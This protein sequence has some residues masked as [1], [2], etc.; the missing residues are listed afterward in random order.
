MEQPA[1]FLQTVIQQQRSYL[2]NA[3]A[4][5]SKAVNND[6]IGLMKDEQTQN[7]D[8]GKKEDVVALGKKS[9]PVWKQRARKMVWPLHARYPNV[10]PNPYGEDKSHYRERDAENNAKTA[11]DESVSLRLG[12]IMVS[13][14]FGPSEIETLY[15]GLEK[16]G[17]DGE[18]VPVRD[19]SNIDWL[20]KQRLYGSEGTMPLGWIHR[21]EEVKKY[22][23][24]RYTADFP[25]EFSSLLV[26]IAQL[27]PSITCLSV[28]F[29]LTDDASLEYANAINEPAKTTR[30]PKRRSR[31]YSIMGVEHV[32]EERVRRIRGKYRNVGI[33]W[34]SKNFPGFFSEH[35]E[36]SHFPTVEFLSLDGFT[37]FDKD[38]PRDRSWNHWSRFVNID[39]DFGSWTSSSIPSLKFSFDA[40]HRKNTPN[41]MTVALRWDVL[42]EEDLKTYGGDSLGTRTYFANDRLDGIIAR[43]ALASYLRELLRS[44]KETRQ[45]LSARS[46]ARCST[47]AIEHISAFFRQSIGVPSIAREVRAL[48]EN[49]ASF[50]WN[51]S[52]FSQ[53]SHRDEEK[54]YEI[55]EGLKSFLGRLSQQLLEE[56]QDTRDF[57]NQLSSALGTKE[58]IAAQRRMEGVTLLALVVAVIS[59]GVAIYTALH[60]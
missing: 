5:F 20:K 21:P 39:H 10:I 7:I 4:L 31:A 6:Y 18:K 28:G 9:V 35:C 41:H 56:D 38:A 44:L 43:Y 34:L 52:G 30:V 36:N 27:T 49:D 47:S 57:L 8:Q 53:Q 16:I 46:K 14:I 15:E 13:E 37:P 29:I 2:C 3:W 11:L 60:T 45:S 25:K 32:K 24:V 59:M 12:C 33:S 51:A 23:G 22:V 17:W 50:R 55:E 48:S 26:N 19:E 40:G 54:P 42:N 1:T 58:S